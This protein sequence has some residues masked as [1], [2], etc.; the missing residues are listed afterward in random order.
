MTAA[1]VVVQVRDACSRVRGKGAR[2]T[3]PARRICTAAA[4]SAAWSPPMREIFTA[5]RY[6]Q[7]RSA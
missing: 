1:D 6:E 4:T 2:C 5:E 7:P 3:S